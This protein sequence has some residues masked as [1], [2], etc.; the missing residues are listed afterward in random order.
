MKESQTWQNAN[1]QE[2]AKQLARYHNYLPK[3]ASLHSSLKSYSICERH[4]NQ[5]IV[6]NQ[7]YRLLTD[8]NQENKQLRLDTD[9]EI[10]IDHSDIIAELETT[11]W[12]AQYHNYI[13]ELANLHS[14]LKSY[15]ICE[16]HYN[17]IIATNQFYCHLTD[18]NQENKRFRLD[19]NEESSIDHSDIIAEFKKTKS[20][21]E[22]SHLE[23]QQKLQSITDLNN[24]IVQM[25][26]HLEDHKV[27]I[28]KLKKKL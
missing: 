15:S 7:F 17:Q 26:Q 13:P 23:I 16:R 12:L 6:T 2:T 14:S 19:T 1:T 28:E 5:I 20:L 21:L 9:E 11:K 10:S 25:H 3:L 24:Q 22:A 4:Y 8:S 27:K 18:S